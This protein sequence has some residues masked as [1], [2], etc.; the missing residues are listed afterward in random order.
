MGN[1]ILGITGAS[2]VIYGHRLLEEILGN[3]HTVHLVVSN[4]GRQVLEHEVG[5]DWQA[6]LARY[7]GS[8]Q[9]IEHDIDD[10]FA[11][12]ASGSFA[13]D[14]MAVTP[15]SMATLSEIAHGNAKN[16]LVR[17]ADVTL[18]E[19]RP[20]ILVPR[21]MPLH[22]IHLENMAKADRT[23]ALILPAMPSFYSHPQSVKE[24]I[25]TVVGRVLD[26]LHIK[27]HL[28]KRWE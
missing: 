23:G 3:G 21:E 14:G 20:L 7:K 18:K 9:L 25:D 10:L 24:L 5:N 17:A 12:I 27:N 19:R 1:Y 22:G 28:F 6:L 4:T 16:L 11:P 13:V 15:C 2:G 8:P 26:H